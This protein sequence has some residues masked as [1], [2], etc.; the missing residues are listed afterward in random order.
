MGSAGQWRISL[1]QAHTKTF[2]FCVAVIEHVLVT[3]IPHRYGLVCLSF[4][5]QLRLPT[6]VL[7]NISLSFSDVTPPPL[8]TD[9][10]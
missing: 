5:L 9:E 2:P 4:L 3:D 8:L 7:G 10:E 6:F 1:E